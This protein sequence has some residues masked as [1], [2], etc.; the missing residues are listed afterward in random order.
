MRLWVMAA[1]GSDLDAQAQMM[2]E[3]LDEITRLRNVEQGLRTEISVHERRVRMSKLSMFTE[4]EEGMLKLSIDAGD[5]V[6]TSNPDSFSEADRK[7][8]A[9]L[10]EMVAV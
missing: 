9:Y 8:M 3:L 7:A 1:T 4:A 10:K 5:Q 2:A 6:V